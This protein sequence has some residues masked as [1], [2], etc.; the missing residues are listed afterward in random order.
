MAAAQRSG[1]FL[2]QARKLLE[3]G[4]A[5]PPQTESFVRALTNRDSLAL[6]QTLA[7][8]EKWKRDALM[9]ILQ[10]W[11]ELLEGALAARGGI[12][13]VSPL[14]RQLAASRSGPELYAAAGELKKALEYAAGNVSPGAIC[15]HLAWALRNQ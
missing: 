14:A 9:E 13:A 5:L 2:G 8:M 15:G 10:S 6:V 12:Q 7:P 4:A 11:V 1:G 3:E